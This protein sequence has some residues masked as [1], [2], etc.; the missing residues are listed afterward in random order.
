M[1]FGSKSNWLVSHEGPLRGQQ[2]GS[3]ARK[4]AFLETLFR[5]CPNPMDSWDEGCPLEG[6]PGSWSGKANSTTLTLSC[7]GWVV[8]DFLAWPLLIHRL[9]IKY[10]LSKGLGGRRRGRQRMRWLDGITDSMDMSLGELR[11]LVMDREAWRAAVHGVAKSQT[12][13][14]DWTEAQ[15]MSPE[16]KNR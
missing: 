2:A 5:Q 12:R 14:S 8:E 1:N 7:W 13:L 16:S 9:C 11:E 4:H 15:K 3:P 10:L 6:F